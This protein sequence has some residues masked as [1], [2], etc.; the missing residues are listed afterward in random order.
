MLA[1]HVV[2]ETDKITMA[3]SEIE[4]KKIDNL[5]GGLCRKRSPSHLKDEF[6]LEY[7][8]KAHDVVVYEQRPHWRDPNEINARLR[9]P[10]YMKPPVAMTSWPVMKSASGVQRR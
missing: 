6:S 1:R 2:L 5:I 3:F 4:L 7:R 9:R 10:Q 8:V